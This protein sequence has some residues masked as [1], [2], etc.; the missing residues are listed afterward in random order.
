MGKAISIKHSEC[1]S[2]ALGIHH[3]ERMRL[4]VLSS[5]AC[6]NLFMFLR[7]TG[8][9]TVVP[10]VRSISREWYDFREKGVLNPKCVFNLLYVLC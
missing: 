2:V 1:V 3:V 7:V 9:R 8:C 4:V 6:L 10:F 5:V